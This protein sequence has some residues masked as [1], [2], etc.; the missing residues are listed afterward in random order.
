MKTAT[1]EG[2]KGPQGSMLDHLRTLGLLARWPLIGTVLFVLG[3]ALFGGFA[4]SLETN[5]PLD[6]ED[7]PV[8]NGLHA[9]ALHSPA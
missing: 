8:G 9:I 4:Y 1:F 2:E 5:G 7:M 3:L 6:R